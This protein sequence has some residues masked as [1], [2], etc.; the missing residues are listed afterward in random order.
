MFNF[1]FKRFQSKPSRWMCF[2]VTSHFARCENVN[3][4]NATTT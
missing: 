2:C 1:V 3:K 4:S